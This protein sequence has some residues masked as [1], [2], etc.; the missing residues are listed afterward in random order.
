VPPVW[1]LKSVCSSLKGMSECC[2]QELQVMSWF[3]A[4]E[5]YAAPEADGVIDTDPLWR[6]IRM[7][8]DCAHHN[9]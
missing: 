7:D 3:N 2:W 8:L 9:D 5:D 1:I 4:L 6:K